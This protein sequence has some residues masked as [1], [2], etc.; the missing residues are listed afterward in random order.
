MGCVGRSVWQEKKAGTNRYFADYQPI[1][2]AFQRHGVEVE[3][4]TDFGG[5]VPD[6]FKLYMQADIIIGLHGAGLT[7]AMFSRKGVVVVEFKSA[8]GSAEVYRKIAQ[9]REG[10]YVMVPMI[11]PPDDVSRDTAVGRWSGSHEA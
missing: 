7:N 8:Y 4:M 1:L 11:T 3:V 10:G 9:S 5:A 2:R 6:Q